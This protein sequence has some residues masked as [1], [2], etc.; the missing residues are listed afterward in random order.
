M[1]ALFKIGGRDY[2]RNIPVPNYTV[3]RLPS[4]YEWT[5]AN[6]LTH[7]DVVRYQIA[8]DFKVRFASKAEYLD[9]IHTIRDGMTRGYVTCELYVN[10][11]DRTMTADCFIDFAPSNLLPLAGQTF[12]A[13]DVTIV[14]R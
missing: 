4:Y 5:D 13:L 11:E 2:T 12:D 10:N 3:N 9:F 8:G 7:R 6:R 1:A 14:E